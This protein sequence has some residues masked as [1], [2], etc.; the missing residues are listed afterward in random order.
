MNIRLRKDA[1]HLW[2]TL[3]ISQEKGTLPWGDVVSLCLS[4]LSVSPKTRK[5]WK[6]EPTVFLMQGTRYWESR[7][8]KWMEAQQAGELDVQLG[9]CKHDAILFHA[10]RL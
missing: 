10:L 4:G 2:K 3:F 5:T 7:R 6:D 1:E 9:L 8:S